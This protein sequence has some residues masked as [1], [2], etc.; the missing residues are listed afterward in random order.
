[1]PSFQLISVPNGKCE[2]GSDPLKLGIQAVKGLNHNIRFPFL[3]EP[4]SVWP[5]GSSSYPWM[6]QETI[7]LVASNKR[8]NEKCFSGIELSFQK[9]GTHNF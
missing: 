7:I 8:T 1:M 5:S 9:D 3:K 4:R 2:V 6:Q